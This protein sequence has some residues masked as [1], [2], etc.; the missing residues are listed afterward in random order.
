ALISG[1][2]DKLNEMSDNS[3]MGE[4]NET[5]AKLLND[6]MSAVSLKTNFQ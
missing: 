5:E 6:R 3:T 2:A 1:L 4:M